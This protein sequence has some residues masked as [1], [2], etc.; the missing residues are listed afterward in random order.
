MDELLDQLVQQKQHNRIPKFVM[1][2]LNGMS[3]TYAYKTK[4]QFIYSGKLHIKRAMNFK[5][6]NWFIIIIVT[7]D[8][9]NHFWLE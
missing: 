8:F 1:N 2:P 3:T 4:L 7:F 6:E 9:C 5:D